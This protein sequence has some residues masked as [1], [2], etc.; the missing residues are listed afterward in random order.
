[1]I[2]FGELALSSFWRNLNLV[3]LILSAI[4]A[5]AI[6]YI[7]DIYRIRQIAKLTLAGLWSQTCDRTACLEYI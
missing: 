7:G 5:C 3:I 4:G 6:I 2:K 1:M